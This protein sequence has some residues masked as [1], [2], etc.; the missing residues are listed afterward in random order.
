MGKGEEEIAVITPEDGRKK[1]SVLEVV[2]LQ[3]IKKRTLI[4]NKIYLLLIT[5][6]ALQHC[7]SGM[8]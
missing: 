1:E 4:P 2:H 8:N 3:K 7:L 6:F 5:F